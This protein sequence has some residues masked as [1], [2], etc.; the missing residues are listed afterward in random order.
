MDKKRAEGEFRDKLKNLLERIDI[1]SQKL[2]E[3]MDIGELKRYRT[4]V[5]EFLDISLRNSTKFEKEHT[6]DSKG[7]HRIFAIVKKVDA[8]LE[9]LTREVMRQ[10]KDN[11]NVLA[12][13]DD[14]RG[15]LLDIIT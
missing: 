4:L 13:L 10:Q 15:M 2:S 8:E 12:K 5:K 9:N 11:L 6:L 3:R 14:I 1:Q 7:R